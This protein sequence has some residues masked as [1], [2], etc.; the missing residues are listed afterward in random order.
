[1]S[2]ARTVLVLAVVGGALALTAAVVPEGSADRAAPAA[3][4]SAAG[5]AY[6]RIE[7]VQG[8]ATASGYEGW[9]EVHAFEWGVAQALGAPTGATRA[10][11]R[12]S[13][14]PL[15]VSKPVDQATP[16]LAQG[17]AAGT[18]YRE[19]EL[20]FFAAGSTTPSGTVKLGDVTISAS[21]AGRGDTPNAME[22]LS[23]SFARIEWSFIGVDPRTGRATGEVK[24]GWDVA[25][26]RP[27]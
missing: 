20:V 27:L 18:H 8:G 19:A 24:T 25:A 4:V 22:T 14:E 1:M 16:L 13:F 7:G 21:H 23:L 12:P 17:C 2:H 10:T 9:I 5:I 3:S 6:L 15:A 11:G 26:N